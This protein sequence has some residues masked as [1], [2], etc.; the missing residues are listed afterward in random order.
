MD[1]ITII[2]STYSPYGG[3]ERVALNLIKGL[4]AMGVKVTLLTLP[5]QNWPITS[6]KLT[7]ICLG[8]HRGHRLMTAWTFNR[9]VAK[10]VSK[11]PCG[12]IFSLDRVI[13]CTHIHAGGGTHKAF[14]KIKNIN[15]GRIS[16]AI[17]SFSLFHRYTLYLE[18]KGFDNSLLRLVRCNSQL[19]KEDILADYGV[20]VEKLMVIPSSIRWQVMGEVFDDRNAVADQL[21]RKHNID[22]QWRC[23]LFLGSGFSR[24][25]L[26]IAIKGMKALDAVYHLLIVGKGSTRQYIRLTARFGLSGRI[27]F[28]GAQ[29]D[30]WRYATM[31]KGLVLPSR[32]EPFG[33]AAAEGH[34]M[35][36]PVL[37]SNKTGYRDFVKPGENGVILKA[38]ADDKAIE[39][40][41]RALKGLIENPM[42]TPIQLRNHARQLDDA[43][44]LDRLLTQFLS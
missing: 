43:V 5:G 44:I 7:I 12:I 15:S 28:L 10:Y 21:R 30:G 24:K 29:P 9:G 22:S 41:F 34:A 27:H 2:R 35:G 6:N 36:V 11:N 8:L 20:P 40:A 42:W 1:Q 38:S 3:V 18:R 17:R 14:L 32:Y 4:L 16:S 23:L 25:G 19:V 31:C 13:P 39:A 33:G 37:I 26:D